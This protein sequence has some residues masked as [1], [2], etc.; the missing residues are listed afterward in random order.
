VSFKAKKNSVEQTIDLKELFG[1]DFSGKRALR[2]VIGQAIIDKIREN[3]DQGNGVAFDKNGVGRSVKLKSPYSDEYA[4][5]LEFKA[6]GKSKDKVNMKLTGDMMG[7]IDV[8]R[9]EGNKVTIGWKDKVEN[10]KAY[11]AVVGD[12]VP[13]RPFFGANK[14][15]LK[16]IKSE[17]KSD[18]KDLIKTKQDEGTK[19]FNTKVFALLDQLTNKDSS[20]GGKG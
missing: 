16:E 14:S 4:D 6:H 15:M 11:N 9:Q 18:V 20:S 13:K 12:T 7:L 3:V 1:V 10:N 19:A 17:F 8:K 5:S 2:E